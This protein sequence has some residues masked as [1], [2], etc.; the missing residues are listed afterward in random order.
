[1]ATVHARF[2][3]GFDGGG[4]GTRCAVLTIDG[5]L[6]AVAH[7]GPSNFQRIGAEQAAQNVRDAITSSAAA[8]KEW[9]EWSWEE[10]AAVF[11]KAS[12][13]GV[14]QFWDVVTSPSVVAE[15]NGP[16]AVE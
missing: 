14:A 15:A 16:T 5:A 2:V 8:W 12:S 6:P 3:L 11:L 9:S 13:L 4:T 10:R 1:M 7:G